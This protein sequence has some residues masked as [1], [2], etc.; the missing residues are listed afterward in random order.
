MMMMHRIRRIGLGMFSVVAILGIAAQSPT[1][2]QAPGE[3]FEVAG[4]KAVRPTLVD[5]I[6][7]LQQGDVAKAKSAFEAYDSG[8]NGIEVYINVR[9]RDLYQAIELNYQKKIE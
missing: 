1:Y 5:T 9:S 2:A 3:R 6:A 4:I 8:W 7:A